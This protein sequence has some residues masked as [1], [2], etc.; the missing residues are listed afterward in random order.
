MVNLR[1]KQAAALF[2]A[3]AFVSSIFFFFP[4]VSS[5]APVTYYIAVPS[6]LLIPNSSYIGNTIQIQQGVPY[7]VIAFSSAVPVSTL[8]TDHIS[9]MLAFTESLLSNENISYNLSNGNMQCMFSK[10]FTEPLCANASEGTS[11]FLLQYGSNTPLIPYNVKINSINSNS[12]F[13]LAFFTS[14]NSSNSSS[15]IPRINLN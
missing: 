8:I 7:S 13:I 9:N 3:I 12:T 2:I 14:S 4:H 10:Q 1:L 15:I 11:W 5:T 6:N